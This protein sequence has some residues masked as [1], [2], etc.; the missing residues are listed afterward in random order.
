MNFCSGQSNTMGGSAVS[1]F[2][3]GSSVTVTNNNC[4]VWGDASTAASSSADKQFVVQAGGGIQLNGNIST[5]GALTLHSSTTAT[6]A[7]TGS[8]TL[9]TNPVGLIKANIGAAPY[10]I[11]YCGT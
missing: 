3:L 9:P 5:T 10:K 8:A 2:A 1:S 11:P 4:F 7:T 6:T